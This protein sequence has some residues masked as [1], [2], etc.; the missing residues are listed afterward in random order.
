MHLSWVIHRFTLKTHRQRLVSRPQVKKVYLLLRSWVGGL[1]SALILF[2]VLSTGNRRPDFVLF[3]CGVAPLVLM[4]GAFAFA[5]DGIT[6]R[7]PHTD[8]GIVPIPKPPPQPEYMQKSFD[9]L[10]HELS[11]ELKKLDSEVSS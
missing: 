2:L 3:I 5:I 7:F 10:S 6:H 8:D 11:A 4:T 9:E 1:L